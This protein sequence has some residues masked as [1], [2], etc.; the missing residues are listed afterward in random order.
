MRAA[1]SLAGAATAPE[2]CPMVGSATGQRRICD[3]RGHSGLRR[4]R[5]GISTALACCLILACA[6]A[7]TPPPASS[8]TAAP[9][10]RGQAPAA[11][12][13]SAVQAAA[14]APTSTPAPI[15]LRVAFAALGTSAA[16]LWI[17]HE[18]GLFREQGLDV[19]LV[20]LSSQRTDQAVI[21]GDPPI[22][23]G[24]NVVAT[25]LS[26]ADIVAVA[27][28]VTQMT[29]SLFVRPGIGSPQDLRGKTAVTTL[30]GAATS[31]A[32][33]IALRHFGLEPNREVA[34]Q[35][36][37]GVTEQFAMM[38]QGHADAALFASGVTTLRAREAG[39]RQLVDL[40]DMGLPFMQTAIAVG[41][42][43]ARENAEV[44]RRFLRGYV[45]AVARARSDPEAAKA[46]LGQYMQTDDAAILE[47]SYQDYR[48][49]WGR[50]D[51]R[52]H[53]EA[54]ASILRVLDAPGA[55]SADPNDFIDNRFIDELH[56]SG[57]VRQVGAAD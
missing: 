25:R 17:G 37:P 43:Y 49:I 33:L 29:H 53:P 6:P 27:G 12:T 39:L 30:P 48:N 15:P 31:L 54:V 11:A 44:V 14:P 26:G 38:A 34:I 19:E 3:W 35:P 10:A 42:G 41:Q 21:T 20:Y 18:R 45:A 36:S 47:L 1:D 55:A 13:P 24:A 50:P 8:A 51:F 32:T 4:Q 2:P 46:V 23:F 56:S 9:T 16:P 7:A 40:G 5:A 28:V 57:F 52:V 22:G